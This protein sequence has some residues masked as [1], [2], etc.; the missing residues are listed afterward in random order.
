MIGIIQIELLR[1][2]ANLAAFLLDA[3][4]PLDDGVAGEMTFDLRGATFA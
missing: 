3:G 1:H 4:A 2:P